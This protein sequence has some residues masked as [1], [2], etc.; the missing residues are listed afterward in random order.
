MLIGPTNCFEV[1]DLMRAAG[2]AIID[3]ILDEQ[4]NDEKIKDNFRKFLKGAQYDLP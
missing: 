1:L 4:T 2:D 3:D